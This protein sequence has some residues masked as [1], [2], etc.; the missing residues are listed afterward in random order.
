MH[1]R[2]CHHRRGDI[3]V[4]EIH[5]EH[6]TRSSV[7][8]SSHQSLLLF[9]HT[10]RTGRRFDRLRHQGR[11]ELCNSAKHFVEVAHGG[12]PL[13]SFTRRCQR[14]LCGKFRRALTTSRCVI[15]GGHHGPTKNSG[16]TKI[17][18]NSQLFQ[19]R[20]QRVQSQCVLITSHQQRHSRPIIVQDSAVAVWPHSCAQGQCVSVDLH[21]H[22]WFLLTFKGHF[23]VDCSV[24]LNVNQEFKH[25]GIW[26]QTSFRQ[27]RMAH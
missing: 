26:E 19:F 9:E 2:Q 25:A 18:T 27:I 5:H 6:S 13:A 4:D 14:Q 11:F 12:H 1:W 10:L 7:G 8:C 20:S 15:H 24:G 16:S 23:F 21:W 3:D 17:S 22:H